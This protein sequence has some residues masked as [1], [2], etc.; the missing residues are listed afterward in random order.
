MRL[1]GS[2]GV[3]AVTIAALVA[4]AAGVPALGGAETSAA[5]AA[6]ARPN[7]VVLMVDDMRKDELRFMPSTQRLLGGQ[8][9]TFTNAVMPNPLCCPS[10]ASVLTGLHSHNHRVWSHRAP[11]GFHSFDDRST[12]PVWLRR[13]GYTTTYL[14]K[15]L[16][17]YGP[18]PPP[19]QTSGRSVQYVPPGWSTWH[20]SIDGG[21]P[22]SH[23]K[24]GG[25]YR[26]FDTTLNNNGN[27]YLNYQG[28]YQTDVYA[29]RTVAQV[30]RLAA[31]AAPFF[32]YVSFTAP[33][34]GGPRES[35]DPGPVKNTWNLASDR[36]QP[37][38]TPARPK[39]VWGKFD[40]VIREA[41]GK[42]WAQVPASGLSAH[43]SS[44]PRISTGEWAGILESARQRAESL[45]VVDTAVGRIVEALRESGELSNTIVVFTSDNGYFLGEYRI[46]QGKSY[47]YWPAGRVPLLMRGPGI[48]AGVVRHD[49]FLSIDHAPTL[50]AAAGAAVPYGADGHSMLDVA[51]S[52]DRGWRHAVLTESAPR[53]AGERPGVLGVRTGDFLY[54]HWRDGSEELFDL[55]RDRS[56]RTS[57]LRDPGYSGALG[58]L[59][60]MLQTLRDCQGDSC[61]PLLPPP[62]GSGA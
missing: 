35:D 16:N 25:T 5:A 54:T 24:S 17:G 41:P 34:G 31:Q 48:P 15:Y 30:K 3:G 37:L 46:R 57:V 62:L 60:A 19:R 51:R 11:W 40:G 44:F 13:A 61:R 12:L 14:G 27:G 8:G 39:R 32:T 22:E 6:S 29:E 56:E 53:K 43:V 36:L 18:Q 55:R 42:K 58:E 45:S 47:P 7:I 52:G 20:G 23:S 4:P 33:H 21:L 50:A 9:A 49:P 26:F 59:R 2:I 10:R 38:V 1:G 28:R